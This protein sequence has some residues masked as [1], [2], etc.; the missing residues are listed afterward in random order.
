MLPQGGDKNVITYGFHEN[1]QSLFD[2]AMF[3]PRAA[4]LFGLSDISS[5]VRSPSPARG[6]ARS[7][8]ELG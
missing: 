3:I 7:D 5:S 2:N 8:A 4:G 6:D 1:Q